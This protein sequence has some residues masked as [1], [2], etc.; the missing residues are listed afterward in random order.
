MERHL[1][2]LVRRIHHEIRRRLLDVLRAH[3]Y[4]DIS[5]AHMYVFARPGPEG[6]RPTELAQRAI[7]TKQAMNHLL[8]GL[9]ANGYLR[10]VLDPDDGR[11]SI[12]R[13]TPKG[14]KLTGLIHKTAS[15]IQREWADKLGPSR[16][17][18]LLHLLSDLD[19][20][21]TQTHDST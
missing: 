4:T 16:M 9:E 21:A 6:C 1:S 15:A 2:S 7:T 13:L 17:E 8:S 18:D 10:R 19:T 14:R 12:V 3:G 11:G 20:I 5:Q